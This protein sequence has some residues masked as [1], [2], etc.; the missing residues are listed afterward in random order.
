MFFQIENDPEIERTFIQI[1]YHT[2]L[3]YNYNAS[4]RFFYEQYEFG[5]EPQRTNLYLIASREKEATISKGD[6]RRNKKKSERE[7]RRILRVLS[8]LL[9]PR[10]RTLNPRKYIYIYMY[11]REGSY[12]VDR[13][14]S[15]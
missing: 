8:F 6:R 7:R 3:K 12:Y 11:V 14:V 10:R 2:Q 5:N 9:F 1:S 4:L 15:R 13:K